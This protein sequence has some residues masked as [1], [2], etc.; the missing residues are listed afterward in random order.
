MESCINTGGTLLTVNN[1]KLL[2]FTMKLITSSDVPRLNKLV[3]FI[4]QGDRFWGTYLQIF[5]VHIQFTIVTGL[6]MDAGTS[7]TSRFLRTRMMQFLGRISLSL[8]LLHWSLIGY[9][10]LAVNGPQDYKTDGEIWAAYGS[11][12]L[13]IPSPMILIII[14]PIVS[15]IVTKYIEEPMLKILTG[16]KYPKT[17]FHQNI[18]RRNLFTKTAYFDMVSTKT[19]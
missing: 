12:K 7:L 3:A 16:T 2:N 11:Q 18:F 10:I 13:I 14:S 4:F 1:Q 8:Y 17:H 5:A 19:V 15:F 9:V 6:C